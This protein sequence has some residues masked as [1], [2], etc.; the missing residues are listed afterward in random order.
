M[1]ESF[2]RCGSATMQYGMTAQTDLHVHF[3]GAWTQEERQALLRATRAFDQRL[4]LTDDSPFG[5]PWV[6][7]RH[8]LATGPLMLLTRLGVRRAF[9]GSSTSELVAALEEAPT[10]TDTSSNPPR[11]D[12]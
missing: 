3:S 6:A 11:A 5:K 7:V 2:P 1:H 4:E 12:R 9:R 8:D 10:A